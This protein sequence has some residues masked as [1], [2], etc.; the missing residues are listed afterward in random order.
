[1]GLSP[2]G[3]LFISRGKLH[4]LGAQAFGQEDTFVMKIDRATGGPIW[5]SQVEPAT[6]G[7]SIM[8][9]ITSRENS[10]PGAA[11]TLAAESPSLTQRFQALE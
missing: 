11:P 5:T 2:A 4:T 10:G 8:R 3:Q 7:L 1:V 6:L 9:A